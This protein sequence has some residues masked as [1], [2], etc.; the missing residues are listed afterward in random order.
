[1]DPVLLARIQFALTIGFHFIF[2]PLTIGMAWMLVWMFSKYKNTGDQFWRSLSRFWM[3]VFALS[4]AAG[5]AT[6]IVMEFQFGTNWSE[7][8]RFVG[9]IFG[10]PLAA[11]GIFTFF[12]ESTFLGVLLFGWKKVS[13]KTLWFASLMVAIGSTLSAFWIIAAN[14]WQQTPAGYH[15][16]VT[17]GFER[18]ELT[19]FWAAVFNPSTLPRYFHTVDGALITGTFFMIGIAAWFLIRGKNLK[20]AKESIKAALVVGFIAALIQLPLGHWHAVQ[21]SHTQPAKMA[22]FEGLFESQEN[23]PV[24]LFGIPD[25]ENETVHAKI[26]IPGLLSM[27]VYNDPSQRVQGLDDF[28]KD[29]WPPMGLTF[30][31]FHFMVYLGMYFIAF[32]GLGLLLWWRGMLWKAKWY[33]YIAMI[34]MVLPIITN[35]LGWIAAEVGRQPW[36][37]YGLMRTNE[38]AS[39]SVGANQILLSIIMFTIVYIILFF[40]WV[41]LVRHQMNKGPELEAPVDPGKPDAEVTS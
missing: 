2:P 25:A 29:E 37:V 33:H 20:F 39:L 10:A 3:K 12:L 28:P 1:M 31:S 18:A 17:E 41:F 26:A 22:T 14:S 34:T 11:E 19:N 16:V 27:L 30:W 23:A 6:G 24:L 21:V 32:T 36:I 8:S 40:V 5:V 4:F 35:E 13:R 7:Y 38:G 15:I 9:D